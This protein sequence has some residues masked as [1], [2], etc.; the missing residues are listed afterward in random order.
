MYFM[1]HI[2]KSVCVGGVRQVR[3]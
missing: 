1:I 3:A 2:F